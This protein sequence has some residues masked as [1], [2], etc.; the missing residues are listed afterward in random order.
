MSFQL[1]VVRSIAALFVAAVCASPASTDAPDMD[2][3]AV[4]VRVATYV[5]VDG[6]SFLEL[7]SDGTALVSRQFMRRGPVHGQYFIKDNE[8]TLT[9]P[10]EPGHVDATSSSKILNGEVDFGPYWWARQSPF[11]KFKKQ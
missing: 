9:I 11:G 7:H 4:P 1:S 10:G 5:E 3:A 6:E 8:L 2:A